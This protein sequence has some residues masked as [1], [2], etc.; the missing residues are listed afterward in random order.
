MSEW[1][2]VWMRNVPKCVKGWQN[3]ITADSKHTH[4]NSQSV[5][6]KCRLALT[7]SLD[8]S[9]TA[10]AEVMANCTVCQRLPLLDNNAFSLSDHCYFFTSSTLAVEEDADD[11]EW[12][13]QGGTETVTATDTAAFAVVVAATA[14]AAANLSHM[15][16]F[17]CPKMT[18]VNERRAKENAVAIHLLN[19]QC[20][21]VHNLLHTNTGKCESFTADWQVQ[22]VQLQKN[23]ED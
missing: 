10:A 4:T 23:A 13:F 6:Q 1:V 11:D 9:S 7:D 3:I 12:V 21:T 19:L 8:S 5:R 18:L 2:W 17:V 22:L 14:A 20:A 15:C 16:K